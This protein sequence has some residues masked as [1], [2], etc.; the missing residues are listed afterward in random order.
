[1]IILRL[2]L[3]S[4]FTFNVIASDLGH[5]R[6]VAMKDF[7]SD[8]I[9]I[10]YGRSV[11]LLFPWP[12]DEYDRELPYKIDLP[13]SSVFTFDYPKG[14]NFIRLSYN[15]KGDFSGE[16]TD[17]H[18]SS[19]GYHFNFVLKS[20]QMQEK[21]YSL[22]NY[23]LTDANRIEFLNRERRR[24]TD[25]IQSQYQEKYD[26][27][28]DLAESKAL[29]IIGELALSKV[30]KSNVYQKGIALDSA[31]DEVTIYVDKVL[32]YGHIYVVPF[33]IENDTNNAIHLSNLAYFQADNN[34][35]N[36][37]SLDYA[38]SYPKKIP[39]GEAGVGYVVTND[40]NYKN[41]M[42][43]H[44]NLETENGLLEVKW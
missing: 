36:L 24:I 10:P 28:D 42:T 35:N 40:R 12:L 19:H 7:T 8:V 29:N 34:Q 11:K 15:A 6:E 18:M 14:Q 44:L 4:L 5:M 26:H 16:I 2:I 17:I 33:E 39:A 23:Q 30:D 21:H 9:E 32:R 20:I 43:N 25:S 31:D 41:D 22:V 27:L 1:M 13:D 38:K 3:F 37:V